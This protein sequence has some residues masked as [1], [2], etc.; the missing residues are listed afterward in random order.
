MASELA[1][2]TQQQTQIADRARGRLEQTR[3]RRAA[4]SEALGRAGRT[5]VRVAAA[6]VDVA[7]RSEKILMLLTEQNK[8]V[9]GAESSVGELHQEVEVGVRTGTDLGAL[10][11]QLEER[12]EALERVSGRFSIDDSQ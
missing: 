12:S 9:T 3:A 2:A 11:A 10:V 7:E 1:A 4:I 8:Q 5:T 6:A